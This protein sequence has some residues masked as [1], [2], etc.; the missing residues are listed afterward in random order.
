MKAYTLVFIGTLLIAMLS[1]CMT[2]SKAMQSFV[3]QRSTELSAR[4]GPP[5]Q[6]VSNGQGGEAWTYFEQHQRTTPGQVNTTVVGT[7]NSYGS[8]YGNANG[9]TYNVNSSAYG[10]ATTTYTTAQ[11]H[12][13]TASRTFF[14][15]GDGIVYRW[16]WEG[17]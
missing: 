5:Q 15:D 7:G 14:V 16:A 1:G 2:P 6:K 12:G 9:A 3:G 8:I 10:A 13:Y 11:T 4:L 17:L